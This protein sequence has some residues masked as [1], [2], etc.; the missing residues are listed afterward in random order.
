LTFRTASAS[1]NAPIGTLTKKIQRQLSESVMR[2]P[3]SGPEATASPIGSATF[4]IVMSTRSMNVVAQTAT[5]VH[6]RSLRAASLDWAVKAGDRIE[7][8]FSR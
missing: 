5:S 7:P 4:T 6:R 2:P 8:S 3:S 1:A